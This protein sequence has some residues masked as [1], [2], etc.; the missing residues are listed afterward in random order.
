MAGHCRRD[1]KKLLFVA[2]ILMNLAITMT[3]QSGNY[4]NENGTIIKIENTD[5]SQWIIRKHLQRVRIGD[6]ASDENLN[7]YM[8]Y[9]NMDKQIGRLKIDEYIDIDRL[10]ETESD[11]FYSVYSNISTDKKISGWIFLGKFKEDWAVYKDPY[12]KNRWEI[13]Q[14]IDN[15]KKWTI[16]KMYGQMVAIWENVNIRNEPGITNTKIISKIVPPEKGN[17]QVNLEVTEATDETETIDNKN[18]RWLKI[19]Y[20]NVEGW[21]FGGY[22]SVERGGYKYYIPENIVLSILGSS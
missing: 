8:T 21:I 1:M 22:A 5:S 9:L 15:G 18:D 19:K 12:Y 2:Y 3:A 4:K 7:I 10:A 13:L 20:H 6:L 14:T 16:R 11:G 17:P